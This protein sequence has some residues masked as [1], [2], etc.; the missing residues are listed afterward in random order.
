MSNN[1]RILLVGT[2]NMGLHYAKVLMSLGGNLTIVGRSEESVERFNDL[3]GLKAISRGIENFLNESKNKVF[4]RCIVAV[5]RENLATTAISLLKAGNASILVEKPGALYKDDIKELMKMANE[6]KAKV[7]IAYNRRFL[8]SVQYVKEAVASEGGVTSFNFDFT[9]WSHKIEPLEKPTG[10]KEQWL[11][12]NSTHV[13]DLAFFLGGEVSKLSCYSSGKLSWHPSGSIFY[14]AGKTTKN[15]LFCYQAN[16]ESAGRWSLEL[17]TEESRYILS[18]LEEV[19]RMKRGSVK[20]E[21]IED[22][23][24]QIDKDFKPGLFLQVEAFLLDDESSLCRIDKQVSNL[25]WFELI[26]GKNI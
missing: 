7:F 10:V 20:V 5:G 16:W 26:A 14:G 22:I 19:K 21:T 15:T 3:T 6:K 11:L 24:Y 17:Q 23:N 8:Q 13:I 2:G 25:K 1:L 4:D 12:L 18:P 9:E